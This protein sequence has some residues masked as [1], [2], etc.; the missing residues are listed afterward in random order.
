[1]ELPIQEK[2]TPEASQPVTSAVPAPVGHEP[3]IGLRIQ[4]VERAGHQIDD[5]AVRRIATELDSDPDSALYR[6]AAT[7]DLDADRIH[8]EL[9]GAY[10]RAR[11]PVVRARI[12]LLG[13]YCIQHVDGE[14]K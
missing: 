4:A 3:D 7:G 5:G 14:H 2:G 1:M 9:V 6:L 13:W 11:D 12:N 10:E 8:H